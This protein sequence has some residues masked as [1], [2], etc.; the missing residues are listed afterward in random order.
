[1]KPVL[2]YGVPSGCSLASV[3]ALEWLAQPY[4]LSRIEMLQQPWSEVYGRINPRMKTPALLMEDGAALTESAAIL[5]HIGGRGI[6]AGL[7]FQQGSREFD[8]LAEMLSYLTT[9]LF[10]AFAPL[11]KLYDANETDPATKD[12]LR[13]LGV[14]SVNKELSYLETVLAERQWL[15]G[16][17]K[18]TVADAYLFAIGRWAEYHEVCR[19]EESYP[20]VHRYLR[21]LGEDPA[22]RFAL[23][24]EQGEQVEGKGSFRGHVGL[25]ELADRIAR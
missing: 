1:M 25:D 9:D 16:G 4:H 20:H 2:F 18:P 17:G 23:D 10:A 6:E 22:V 11:W 7:G 12:V 15:L 13:R 19:L 3:I 8:S 21:R 5:Q 14:E 24:I